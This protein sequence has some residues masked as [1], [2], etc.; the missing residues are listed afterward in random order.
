MRIR[1]RVTVA[2]VVGAALCG[3]AGCSA[4]DSQVPAKVAV[5]A[6]ATN[7][8]MAAPPA[9]DTTKFGPG[10]SAATAET[11]SAD[12][13]IPGCGAGPSKRSG[14]TQV[15]TTGP[16]NVKAT[17]IVTANQPGSAQS[18]FDSTVPVLKGCGGSGKDIVALLASPKN[19]TNVLGYHVG[20][21]TAWWAGVDNASNVSVVVRADAGVPVPIEG[22]FDLWALNIVTETLKAAAGQPYGPLPALPQ[23]L[24]ATD[25]AVDVNGKSTT[26]DR[27]KPSPSGEVTGGGGEEVQAPPPDNGGE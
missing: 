24:S 13:L 11:A 4:S 10:W 12:L 7:G 27:V 14:S 15:S 3:V 2:V 26:F 9:P 5:T 16:Q 18:W 21:S 6:Q 25:V 20:S 17:I 1:A 19:I 8:D 22:A 23:P